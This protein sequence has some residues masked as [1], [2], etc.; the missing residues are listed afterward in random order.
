[1]FIISGWLIS[2]FGNCG[3]WQEW[4]DLRQVHLLQWVIFYTAQCIGILL[5]GIRIKDNLLRDLGV[6]F[7]LLDLYTRY[8]EYLWDHTN[9]GIFFGVLALSFWWVGRLIEQRR[10]QG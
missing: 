9:K 1:M 3:T 8:F 7:L 6:I 2:I 4:Q 10:K 5:L